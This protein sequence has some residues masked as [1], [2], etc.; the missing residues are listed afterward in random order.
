MRALTRDEDEVCS[1]KLLLETDYNVHSACRRVSSPGSSRSRYLSLF[2]HD[3]LISAGLV[4]SAS[5]VEAV[6]VSQAHEVRH[7]ATQSFAGPLLSSLSV[8]ERP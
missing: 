2:E 1:A 5:V 7:P 4:N 3:N 8:H 6:S